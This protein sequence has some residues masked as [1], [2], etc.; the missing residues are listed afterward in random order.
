MVP[1]VKAEGN[2]SVWQL[3]DIVGCEGQLAVKADVDL[4]LSKTTDGEAISRR[5]AGWSLGSKVPECLEGIF[6]LV[7]SVDGDV[8]VYASSH[9]GGL[10]IRVDGLDHAGLAVVAVGLTAVDPDRL[11][12]IDGDGECC[13][14]CYVL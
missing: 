14:R 11:G 4:E 3:G 8:S 7:T 5:S 13:W 9:G 12:I 6:M 1:W 2:N 10:D